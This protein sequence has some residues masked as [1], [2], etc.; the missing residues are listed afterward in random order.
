MERNQVLET[1]G[2]MADMR[3]RNIDHSPTT[4]VTVSADGEAMSFRAGRAQ[5]LMIPKSSVPTVLKY[6]G[7]TPKLADRLEPKTLGTVVTEMLAHKNQ[8]AVVTQ[9]GEITDFVKRGERIGMNPAKVL[10]NIERALPDVDYHRVNCLTLHDARLEILGVN[11]RA[12]SKGDL[13]RAGISVN[14]SPIGVVSPSVQ[15]YA[16]RLTCTNGATSLSSLS[17]YNY[18]GGGNGGNG[19]GDGNV[20][21]WLRNSAR[22]AYGSIDN[23]VTSYQEMMRENITPA[24]RSAVIE[25][26]IREARLPA[27][28]AAEVRTR[29]M[30]EPPQNSYDAMNLISWASS[31]RLTGSLADHAQRVVANYSNE[32]EHRRVCP[33]CRHQTNSSPRAN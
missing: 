25:G 2:T 7:I 26:L 5:A 32:A 29:A 6:T 19:G 12:V 18:G 16:L 13:I 10:D 11:E 1:L 28:V 22:N 4:R 14:F 20:W 15:A 30:A 8:Y 23:I 3:V 17:Q 9:D 31:H 27:E 21:N 33:V 24:D